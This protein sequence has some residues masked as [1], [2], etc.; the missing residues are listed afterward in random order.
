ML[1]FVLRILG[2]RRRVVVSVP[3]CVSEEQRARIA[4]RVREWINGDRDVIAVTE[5]V[6]IRTV[7]VPRRVK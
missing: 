2:M 3:P 7:T 6:E 1:R 4:D 5:G